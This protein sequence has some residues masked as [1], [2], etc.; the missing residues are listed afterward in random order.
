[1]GDYVVVVVKVIICMKGEERILVVE[2]EIN[3]MG[4]VVKN[5]F[6]EVLIVYINGDDEKVYEV[7]VMDE[8]VDD[9]F[10]DI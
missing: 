6:E 10:C 5:M 2:L 1:M 4:K 7:V 8:I 3:N 9:Y